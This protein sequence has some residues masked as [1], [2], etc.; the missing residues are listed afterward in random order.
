MEK[1][2]WRSGKNSSQSVQEKDEE[3]LI[4]RLKYLMSMNF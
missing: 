2:K 4:I 1:K 3:K